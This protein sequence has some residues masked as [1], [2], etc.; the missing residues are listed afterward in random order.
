MN[1]IYEEQGYQMGI[2]EQ[3]NGRFAVVCLSPQG[4]IVKRHWVG[5]NE[6]ALVEVD[7]LKNNI[8]NIIQCN[9]K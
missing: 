6:E 1:V 3:E 7:L 5:T 8:R 9:E 2:I 4:E